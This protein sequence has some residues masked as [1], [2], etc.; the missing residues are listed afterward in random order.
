[1]KKPSGERVESIMVRCPD[2]KIPEFQEL[3]DSREYCV[4][5]SDFT[6][7]GGD[8]FNMIPNEKINITTIG[9]DASK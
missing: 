5:T 9:S 2:C 4:L 1:M 7:G 6:A 3:E 8:G